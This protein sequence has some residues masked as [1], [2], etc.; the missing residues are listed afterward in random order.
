M[1]SKPLAVLDKHMSPSL[2]RKDKDQLLLLELFLAGAS[3]VP[4]VV[5]NPAYFLELRN[6]VF[7]LRGRRARR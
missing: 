1:S 3:S 6:C 2:I 4:T 5:V 7:R